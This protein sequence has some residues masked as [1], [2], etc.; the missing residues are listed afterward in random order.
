MDPGRVA[1]GS[2]ICDVVAPGDGSSV[3]KLGTEENHG[4]EA[5][6][7]D[8]GFV[9][10]DRKLQ[11]PVEATLTMP[12]PE[13]GVTSRVYAAITMEKAFALQRRAGPGVVLFPGSHGD[14]QV[15]GH[16][17]LRARQLGSSRGPRASGPPPVAETAGRKGFALNPKPSE[18]LYP[19]V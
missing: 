7:C 9:P 10:R 18:G 4:S 6:F 2:C 11:G 17:R 14:V 12:A 15:R 8:G 1:L 16:Q 3:I 5:R 19:K 13:A